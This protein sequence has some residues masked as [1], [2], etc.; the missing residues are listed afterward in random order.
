[1][2]KN[3]FRKNPTRQDLLREQRE[4]RERRLGSR[5]DSL[6]AEDLL[7]VCTRIF[8]TWPRVF[9]RRFTLES[10]RQDV[11]LRRLLLC[12]LEKMEAAL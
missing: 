8:P 11:V 10:A 1:M 4:D 5:L 12:V 6:A 7:R 2:Q 9:G 3:L